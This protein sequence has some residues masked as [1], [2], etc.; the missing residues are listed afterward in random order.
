MGELIF[1]VVVDILVHVAVKDLK[2]SGIGCN[3]TP[4]W[5]FAVLDSPQFVV[6]HPKVGLEDFGRRQEPQDCRISLGE[7]PAMFSG[8]SWPRADELWVNSPALTV[9][10]PAAVNPFL[11]NERRLIELFKPFSRSFTASFLSELDIEDQ[12]AGIQRGRLV[13]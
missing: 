10:A 6:L 7:T 4:A 8:P 12:G 3:S 2:G 13:L 5:D 1:G 11:M 9:A